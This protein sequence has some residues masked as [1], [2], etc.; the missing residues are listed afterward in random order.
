MRID[1][2]CDQQE[3]LESINVTISPPFITIVE[4]TDD[5]RCDQRVTGETAV[6]I[7]PTVRLRPNPARRAEWVERVRIEVAVNVVVKYVAIGGVRRKWFS[8]VVE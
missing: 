8:V 6:R 7:E 1:E 2:T 4:P 3:R 5:S